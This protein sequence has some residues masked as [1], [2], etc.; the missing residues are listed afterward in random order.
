[1]DSAKAKLFL[2]DPFAKLIDVMYI[3]GGIIL[4]SS[5]FKPIFVSNEGEIEQMD[6]DAAISLQE[7][8]AVK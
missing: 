7:R 1:M 6:Y 8:K 4:V 5:K 2:K 3:E